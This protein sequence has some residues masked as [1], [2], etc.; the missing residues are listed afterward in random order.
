M[1]HSPKD[2]IKLILSQIKIGPWFAAAA[3]TCRAWSQAARELALEMDLIIPFQVKSPDGYAFIGNRLARDRK[4]L[5]GAFYQVSQVPYYSKS[6]GQACGRATITGNYEYGSLTGIFFIAWHANEC[7]DPEAAA[8]IANFK[9]GKA[10]GVFKLIDPSGKILLRLMYDEGYLASG[11]HYPYSVDA[12]DCERCGNSFLDFEISYDDGICRLC[13]YQ[14]VIP[15]PRDVLK[16]IFLKI[17]DPQTF[18]SAAR[19]CREYSIAAREAVLD[20]RS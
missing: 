1:A 7:V 4:L 9:E 17:D 10:H 12:I 14:R 15:L 3:R 11:S 2:V 6:L 20:I 13:K 19:V 18:A 16:L 8:L 5:H